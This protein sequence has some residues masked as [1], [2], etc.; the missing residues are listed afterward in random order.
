MR[1]TTSTIRPAHTSRRTALGLLLAALAALHLL[2]AGPADAQPK[3]G[4]KME[5]PVAELM[6]E[7]AIPDL[8]F[9][10][11]DAPVTIVEYASLTCGFCGQFHAQ[12]FPKL[13]EKYIDTGKAK[14]HLRPFA[15]NNVDAAAWML[16]QCAGG[17]RGAL[18]TSILLER[19]SQWAFVQNPEPKLLAF[20]K[21]AGFTNESFTACIKDEKKLQGLVTYRE[22]AFKRFGVDATPVLFINGKRFAGTSLDEFEKALAP[23]LPK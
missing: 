17:E 4:T 20:A 16:A 10:K 5:V 19:Q 9:G 1:H 15:Q 13:K 3:K 21:Q 2:G 18:L 7:S 12:V 14:L 8:V 23:H 11:A 6:R 22:N